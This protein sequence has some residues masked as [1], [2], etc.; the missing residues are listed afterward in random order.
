MNCGRQETL[1][2]I[3]RREK[4]RMN[5]KHP[6]QN[7]IMQI[8]NQRIPKYNFLFDVL[9]KIHLHSWIRIVG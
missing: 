9:D 4:Q 1:L 8:R 2:Q 7:L 5:T 6:Y 3:A